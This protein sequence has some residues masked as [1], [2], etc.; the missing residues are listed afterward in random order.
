MRRGLRLHLRSPREIGPRSTGERPLLLINNAISAVWMLVFIV[1][2][3]VSLLLDVS[4]GAL[5]SNTLAAL[6]VA[7]S[8][9]IP[10]KLPE[11]L[12]AKRHFEPFKKFDRQV[13]ASPGSSRGEDDYD[14][15]V[16]G[17]GIGGLTCGSLFAKR[18]YRVLVLEQ[19]FQVGGHRSSF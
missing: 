7:S 1:N 11:Y 12:A 17:A 9:I 15:V 6:G 18:G 14:V 8:I 13:K 5:L 2:A 16:V 10:A 3:I 4:Y 19:H